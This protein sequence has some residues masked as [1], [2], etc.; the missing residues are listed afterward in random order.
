MIIDIHSHVID[1]LDDG[2]PNIDTAIDM[3]RIAAKDGITHIIATPHYIHGIWQNN[4][5]LVQKKINKLIKRIEQENISV[6]L[7]PGNEVFISLEVPELIKEGLVCTLNHSSYIL[8]ELPIINIPEYTKDIIFQLKLNG[9]TPI[10]AHPERNCE[11]A[12]NPNLLYDF[13]DRGALAQINATSLTGIYGSRT[14]E[15]ALTLL[16]HGM[17]H[18][19]ASDAHNCRGRTFNLSESKKIV[20]TELGDNIREALFEKNGQCVLNDEVIKSIGHRRVQKKKK[21][22][23]W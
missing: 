4:A 13:I 23:G 22:F 1:G 9:H 7:F 12:D 21:R 3:I 5:F 10:I 2:A 15:V 18:F 11:V 8:L 14:K 20:E 17:A 19:I 16:R 6:Q